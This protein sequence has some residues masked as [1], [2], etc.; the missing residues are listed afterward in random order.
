MSLYQASRKSA[1]CFVF[2]LM[3]LST[4]VAQAA[5][6]YILDGSISI[7]I[8]PGP[9]SDGGTYFSILTPT[10]PGVFTDGVYLATAD[11]PYE[12]FTSV[13][14]PGDIFN[15]FHPMIFNSGGLILDNDYP[16]P[17]TVDLTNGTAD[18]RSFWVDW[19]ET[20]L[21][22]DLGSASVT[23]QGDGTYILDWSMSGGI[24]SDQT[25]HMT[26]HIAAVPIPAAIWLLGTGLVTLL[27]VSRRKI[28]QSNH[29]AGI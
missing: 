15:Y 17:I 6:W 2:A 22:S 14:P 7:A 9:T 24:T 5:S 16:P 10:A 1:V 28:S 4:G 18:M 11:T 21:F 19:F 23:L 26:M 20:P 8:P 27:G 25:T 12:M 3:C 29:W 13:T